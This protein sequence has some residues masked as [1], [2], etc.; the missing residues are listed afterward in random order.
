M[1]F[2]LPN[3]N[4][5]GSWVLERASGKSSLLSA[6]IVQS[7]DSMIL[8]PLLAT[9][10][11]ASCRLAGRWRQTS[12][13]SQWTSSWTSSLLSPGNWKFPLLLGG[14]DAFGQD[15]RLPEL[16]EGAG[17]LIWLLAFRNMMGEK[18]QI[19]AYLCAT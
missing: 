8:A 13:W 14:R 1:T 9:V 6:S 15:S 12:S 17:V 5:M 16:A 3:A 4:A 2:S 18:K 19:C 10:P 7:R 11:L